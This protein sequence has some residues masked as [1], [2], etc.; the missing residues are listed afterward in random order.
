M[1]KL[2][3]VIPTTRKEYLTEALN[4][5]FNQTLSDIRVIIINDAPNKIDLHKYI[6]KLKKI[7]KFDYFKNPKN[8]GLSATRNKGIDLTDS[9]YIFFLDDDDYLINDYAFEGMCDL[10]DK[11]GTDMAVSRMVATNDFKNTV[12]IPKIKFQDYVKD[13]SVCTLRPVQNK[14]YRTSYLRDNNLRFKD[15]YTAEEDEFAFMKLLPL[16]PSLSL[17]G[18]YLVDIRTHE[19]IRIT[20]SEKYFKD[21]K[22]ITSMILDHLESGDY[23]EEIKHNIAETLYQN[24]TSVKI[25]FEGR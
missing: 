13:Y 11:Y 24:W 1:V 20:R 5:I 22:I 7:Y 14:I 6:L 12:D 18:G 21:L 3:V 10:L 4:T 25:G 9:E 19:G 8:I 16:D 23:S 17:Y 15:N 2:T